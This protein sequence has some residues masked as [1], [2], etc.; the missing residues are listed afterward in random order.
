MVRY[1]QGRGCVGSGLLSLFKQ[2]VPLTPE[3]YGRLGCP[4][5]DTS[6]LGLH[7]GRLVLAQ[8]RTFLGLLNG[9]RGQLGFPQC[10][11]WANSQQWVP[12]CSFMTGASLGQCPSQLTGTLNAHP[13]YMPL[14]FSTVKHAA[15]GTVLCCVCI[16]IAHRLEAFELRAL[17]F[18]TLVMGS[19]HMSAL[20]AWP[21]VPH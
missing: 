15:L 20:F 11:T 18:H 19:K 16:F 4:R 5:G 2:E 10:E 21:M 3:M 1:V 12:Q 8:W 14:H 17:G 9:G 7:N 13:Y 6:A